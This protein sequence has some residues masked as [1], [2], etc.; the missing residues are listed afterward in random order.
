MHKQPLRQCS[1]TGIPQDCTDGYVAD[2]LENVTA[3]YIRATTDNA[4][5]A[6]AKINGLFGGVTTLARADAPEGE[7]AFVTSP[8]SEKEL[9][10]KLALVDEAKIESV[11]RITNY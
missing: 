11:I 6:V 5:A 8:V 2:Y 7:L 4:A 10:E 9:D 3:F 1:D